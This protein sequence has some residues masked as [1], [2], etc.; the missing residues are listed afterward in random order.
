MTA[1]DWAQRG[2]T[3]LSR[4]LHAPTQLQEKH[5]IMDQYKQ[6]LAANVLGDGQIVC[7]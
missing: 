6:Y 3:R 2:G 7:R 4:N 1:I 5:F